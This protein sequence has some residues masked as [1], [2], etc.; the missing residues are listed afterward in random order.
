MKLFTRLM[1]A[2]A[3][4]TIALPAAAAERLQPFVLA[5]KGAG[6][7]AAT[8]ADVKKKLTGAGFEV[9]GEY[10]PY[11]TV[12]LVIVTN[13]ALKAAAAKSEFGAYG[14]AQRISV[15]SHKGEIQV[16]YTNPSYMA[17]VYRM[18][19]DLAAVATAMKG[20]LGAEL[21]YGSEKGLKAKKLRKYHYMF[22]MP[23]FDDPSEL[24]EHKDYKSAV[25]AVERGLAA[26]KSGITKVYRI[27]IP[28]KDETVFGVAMKGAKLDKKFQ[29]DNYIMS[30]VDF[31]DI[32]S[33]AHLPYEL[34]VSGDTVYALSAKFR[35]AINFPDLKMMGDN[36]FMNIMD[37][38]GAIEDALE[39]VAG[40]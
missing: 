31:Q 30:E 14:A 5:S 18:K 33:S 7:M 38:P 40:G 20:A 12:S 10:S 36:S 23:Y 22:G 25:A 1:L 21:T 13:N 32:R 16:A 37:S 24:A 4:L 19:D 35:I 9:V 11:D 6:D 3:S 2:L 8:V 34:V 27:D 15:T 17:N 29:D 39:E 26:G 28:G